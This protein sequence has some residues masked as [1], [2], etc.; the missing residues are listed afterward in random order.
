MLTLAKV[1]LKNEKP[2]RRL[3]DFPQIIWLDS[4]QIADLLD[5]K[6]FCTFQADIF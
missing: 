4:D 6:A 1:V 2:K 5:R 3:C